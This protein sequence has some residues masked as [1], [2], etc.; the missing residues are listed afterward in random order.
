MEQIKFPKP[1][2][3]R[4]SSPFVNRIHPITKKK[5]FHNGVDI[6]AKIGTNILS[7]MDGEVI[8]VL[9]NPVGGLQTVIQHANGYKTGYAH[10]ERAIWRRGSKVSAGQVIATVGNS[11]KS[12]GPHLHFTVRNEKNEYVDPLTCFS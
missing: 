7:P 10:L 1:V 6:A 5:S 11:G 9:R 8:V 4:I 2:S 3:G 12:T